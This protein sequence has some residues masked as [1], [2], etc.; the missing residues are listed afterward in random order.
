L[1]RP[2]NDL[3]LCAECAAKL[4]RDLIRE[5]AWDYSATAFTW[6][7]NDYETLR[8]RVI[9]EYGAAYEL[10]VPEGANKKQQSKNKNQRNKSPFPVR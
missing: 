4:E 10:I 8:Q 6:D 5:R 7:P 1:W 9:A 3:G 2:L